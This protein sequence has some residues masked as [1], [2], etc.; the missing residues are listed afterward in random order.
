MSS[1]IEIDPERGHAQDADAVEENPFTDIV[2][3][4]DFYLVTW[5]GPDDPTNPYNWPQWTKWAVT[6]LTSLGGM[7]TLMAS[8]MM[9][10]A[11][12]A[13]SQDLHTD[14]ATTQ[15]TLSIFVL[16]YAFGP[17]LLAPMTEVFGRKPIWI[18]SC[19]FY[20]LWNT[21]CGFSLT[22]S[23]MI[24]SRFFSGLGAS[25]QY[26]VEFPVL[27]DC[28]KPE[29]RGLSFAIA[30]FLP[31]LGPAIGP[32]LGGVMTGSIG[33]RWIFWVLS[34][35]DAALM[36]AAFFLFPETYA[37]A[38]LH[39]KAKQL[40]KQTGQEYYTEYEREDKSLS[41]VLIIGLARP[42]RMLLTQPLIQLMSLYLAY[43]Y[44]ILYIVQ[45]TFAT[46]WIE[47]YG[48]SV[49]VSGLHYIALAAGSIFAAQVGARVTDR[50]W[51]HLKA[52][53]QGETQPEYRIPLMAPGAIIIPVGLFWYGWAAETRAFWLLP[54]I[55]IAIFA[56]GIIIGTQAMQA[57]VMDSFPKHVASATAA[58]QLL[59]NVAG[60]AFPLFAPKM[61]QTFGYGWGNSLLA[62]IF[63][64]IGFPAPLILWKYGA[65]LR[66]MGNQD[67]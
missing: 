43:N 14:D 21:V 25:V 3:T 36:L 63:I 60:F 15:M 9:A 24:A 51:Q 8:T 64:A 58:S 26:A 54:D 67:W 29:Q 19:C 13:I 20:I 55:G 34:I 4:P 45:S 44:G 2:D 12:P 16:S 27:A 65:K 28:W 38:I 49:T 31:L 53:A 46:L 22:N 50:V 42:C 32:I 30:T 57:Y 11:L 52:R 39:R 5:D 56:C 35:F 59:R 1:P 6:I 62:F 47:R 17:M 33:W 18:L 66:T 48:Q 7:V 10:P 37:G 61:Y 40:R 41:R 23:V